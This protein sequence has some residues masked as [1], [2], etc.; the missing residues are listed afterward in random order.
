MEGS[1]E[2]PHARGRGVG[3][4]ERLWEADVERLRGEWSRASGIRAPGVSG[5]DAPVREG[6]ALAARHLQAEDVLSR[7]LV[8]GTGGSGKTTVARRLDRGWQ[9]R[10]DARPP[11][12]SV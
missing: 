9:L 1:R 7:I 12:G 11:S 10:R 8:I 2:H 3:T 5:G 4:V 6:L